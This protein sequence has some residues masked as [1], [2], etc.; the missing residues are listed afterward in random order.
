METVRP[1]EKTNLHKSLDVLEARMSLEN[2]IKQ[3]RSNLQKGYEGEQTF[4]T[5][6]EKRHSTDGLVLNN[7]MLEVRGSPIQIDSLVI[8]P[9][10]VYLYEIKNYSGE[11]KMEDGILYTLS[12]F[13]VD[14]PINQLERT[15]SRLRQLFQQWRVNIKIEASIIFVHPQF[16]LYNANPKHPIVLHAQINKHLD[17]INSNGLPLLKWHRQLANKLIASIIE[18]GSY[19]KKTPS[20]TYE[21]LDKKVGCVKCLSWDVRLTQRSFTC[22]ACHYKGTIEELV[23]QQVEDFRLLF[24]D[25]RVTRN[26]IHNWCGGVMPPKKIQQILSRNYTKRGNTLGTYYE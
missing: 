9:D 10:T 24:P 19:Q 7:V 16:V 8:A 1:L 20:Y 23:L 18:E 4:Q 17:K 26:S 12:G 5:F 14:N 2:T 15:Q 6:L 22:S 3:D 13:E 11:Y 21:E 25:K